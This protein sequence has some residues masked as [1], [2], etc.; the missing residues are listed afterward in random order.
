MTQGHS[1]VR[2]GTKYFA[3]PQEL[4]WSNPVEARQQEKY[5]ETLD[6][7]F[8]GDERFVSE[9]AER[10]QAREVE[11]KQKQV[12]FTRLLEALCV[13]RHVERSV[14]LQ[15]GRQGQWVALRAQLVYLGQEWC[16]LTNKGLATWS[17]FSTALILMAVQPEADQP[18]AETGAD[19]NPTPTE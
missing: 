4:A 18:S 2:P 15:P 9:V 8:L 14:L 19:Q 13:M 10:S 12:G 11:I 1:L 17:A 5:Y 7:R 6:Q 16:R 3:I